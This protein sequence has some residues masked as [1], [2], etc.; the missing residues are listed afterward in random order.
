MTL[1]LY[2]D[3]DMSALVAI[4]LKSRGIDIT[5][6]PEQRTLGK[7]DNQQLEFATCKGR[8]ILTHNR[9]D[10]E[11]LHVQYFEEGKEHAGVIVVPQKNAYEV[12]QRVGVLVTALM[13]S[14]IKNQLLYA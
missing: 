13:V 4:L 1:A 14:N 12:A 7:T 8:C 2:T 6:V 3:E 11:R 10:F 5:T 9:I